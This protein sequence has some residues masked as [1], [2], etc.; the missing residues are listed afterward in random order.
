[1]AIDVQRRRGPGVTQPTGDD[2]N[3]HAGIKHLSR[4]EVSGHAG[5]SGARQLLSGAG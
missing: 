5:E 4:H 2:D 3:G 1:M